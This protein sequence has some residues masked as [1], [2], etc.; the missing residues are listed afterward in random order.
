RRRACAAARGT[1][2]IAND[3]RGTDQTRAM[4]MKPRWGFMRSFSGPVNLTG[5][6]PSAPLSGP[7][8]RAARER[9][10]EHTHL[11]P[12]V[13]RWPSADGALRTRHNAACHTVPA[14]HGYQW[15]SVA[16]SLDLGE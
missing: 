13:R 4:T 16:P 12:A 14:W 10:R 9:I 1:Y 15:A 3:A 6:A 8:V 2:Q 7:P 5:K 11:T